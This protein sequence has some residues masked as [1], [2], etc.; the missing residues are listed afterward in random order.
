LAAGEQ[1]QAAADDAA[2][3]QWFDV[4]NLPQPRS[5]QSRCAIERSET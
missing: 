5:R 4:D 2:Q 3:V 1:Q